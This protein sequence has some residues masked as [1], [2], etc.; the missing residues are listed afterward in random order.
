VC[1]TGSNHTTG[2]NSGSPALNGKGELIGINFDRTWESTMSDIYFN[3]EICRNVMV[4]ARY[5]LWVIDVYGGA[6]YLLNEMRLIK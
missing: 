6:G 1:F 5:V 4:D 2:G 3:S